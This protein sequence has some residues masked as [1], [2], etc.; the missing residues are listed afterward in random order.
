[1][2]ICFISDVHIK[3]SQDPIYKK[4]LEAIQS[5]DFENSDKLFFL[6]DIFDLMAGYH[7]EYLYEFSEFFEVVKRYLDQGKEVWF[8]EGNHDVHLQKLLNKAWGKLNFKVLQKP[9]I[10]NHNG[11]RFYIS[12]GDE[13]DYT[14]V[15]YQRYKKFIFS[16]PLKYFA[17][18]IMPY[19]IL[20]YIG[21]R[22]SIKSRAEGKK[23]FNFE[24]NKQKFRDLASEV[25]G[26]D[27]I[28]CGHTHIKD[29][30]ELNSETVYINLGWFPKD[31][32][33][34]LYDNGSFEFKDLN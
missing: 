32:S 4:L 33:Y 23:K 6:G 15:S 25:E 11:K 3:T 27:Y 22:A 7:K 28:I 31:L 30:F 10:L 26:F 18:Y 12:H 20:E 17:N 24:K 9:E 13:L 29:F 16:K 5:S 19:S 14:D 2:K 34:L 1:M 8:F 21:R